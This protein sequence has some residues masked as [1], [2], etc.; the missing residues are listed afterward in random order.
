MPVK[1]RENSGISRMITKWS[2]T[3]EIWYR[4]LL[5]SYKKRHFSLFSLAVVIP[6]YVINCAI[7]GGCEPLRVAVRTPSRY[8]ITMSLVEH[9]W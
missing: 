7:Q 8:R 2:T 5:F 4:K 1:T 3:T 6:F 9:R